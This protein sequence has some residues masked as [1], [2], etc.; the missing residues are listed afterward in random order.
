MQQLKGKIALVTGGTRGIG[1][2]ITEL[3]AR[4][5]A[6]VYFTYAASAE[7]AGEI[8]N[9]LSAE[10]A[11]CIAVSCNGSIV[12]SVNN[13]VNEIVSKHGRLDILVNNAGITR[14]NIILR[15]S[16]SQWQEVIDNNL[17]AAFYYCRAASKIMLRTGGSIINIS[18][19]VGVRGNA[20]QSNYAASKAGMIGLS[21]SLALELGSRN[22]RCNVITPGFIDT[23]MTSA[24]PEDVKKDY[25]QQIPLKRFGTG[26]DVA[27]LALFL[28]TDHSAY[29]TGQVLSVCGGM[30]T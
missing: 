17:T 23:E 28:A 14:D 24:L 5:G 7:L 18:S 1:R 16:D 2:A 13:L 30:N 21:K 6:T 12:D 22:I 3:Y 15:M 26:N 4:Q 27:E 25:V 9:I 11:H 8:V 20:G 29:I 10:N 19:V